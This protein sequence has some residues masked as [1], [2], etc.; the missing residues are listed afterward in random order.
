MLEPAQVDL[1]DW[2]LGAFVFGYLWVI[3]LYFTFITNKFSSTDSGLIGSMKS[4]SPILTGDTTIWKAWIGINASHSSGAIF[5]SV[6]NMYLA[7]YYFELFTPFLF[8]FNIVTV[9]I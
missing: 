1:F 3:H 8:G 2:E 6:M 5:I 9:L 7:H 4:S